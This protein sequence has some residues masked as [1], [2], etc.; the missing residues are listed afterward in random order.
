MPQ[1]LLLLGLIPNINNKGILI[2]K[3]RLRFQIYILNIVLFETYLTIRKNYNNKIIYIYMIFVIYLCAC[4]LRLRDRRKE[5][6]KERFYL[7]THFY[8]DIW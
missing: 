4:S 6:R 8:S 5:G 2:L 1:R 7:T 3:D